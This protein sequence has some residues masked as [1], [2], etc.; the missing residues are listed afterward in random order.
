[1]KLEG[2]VAIITGGASGIG[3]ATAKLFSGEGA[4]VVVADFSEKGQEVADS[5]IGEAIF[6]KTD[7]SKEEDIKDLIQSTVDKFGRVDIMFANA[8]IG[9]ATPA[10]ELSID[11]WQKMI[12]VNLTGVF[13]SNKHA[14]TNVKTGWWW[15]HCQ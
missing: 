8:G 13:L 14:Q 10:H 15:F 6:V 12:D 4:S 1:M 2:K 7:V 9:D 5:L 3:E 11:D